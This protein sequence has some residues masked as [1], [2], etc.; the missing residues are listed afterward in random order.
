V[1]GHVHERFKLLN[2]SNLKIDVSALYVIAG[3]GDRCGTE[4][5]TLV[6][7]GRSLRD[8]EGLRS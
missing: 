5:Q 3:G 2:F 7:C 6:Q 8:P 1:I 4:G